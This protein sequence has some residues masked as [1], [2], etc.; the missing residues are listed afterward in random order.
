MPWQVLA[1][2]HS[3]DFEF[4]WTDTDVW[5]VISRNAA[6]ALTVNSKVAGTL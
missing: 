3:G 4:S 6:V 2:G 5:Q 1:P